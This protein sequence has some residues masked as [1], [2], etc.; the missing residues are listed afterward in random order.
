[1]YWPNTVAAAAMVGDCDAKNC[2]KEDFGQMV[3]PLFYLPR[4]YDTIGTMQNGRHTAFI[5]GVVLL[6]G[7]IIMYNELFS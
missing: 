3:G 4:S 5:P 1:M 7:H 2:E 6:M